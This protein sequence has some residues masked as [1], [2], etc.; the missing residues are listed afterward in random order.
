VAACAFARDGKSRWWEEPMLDVGRREF[1]MLA[2]G[3]A[4]AWPLVARSQQLDRIARIG[5]LGLPSASQHAPRSDA[6]RAGL[7]NLGYIEGRNLHIEFRFAEGDSDRLPGLAAEL[8]GL[9]VDVIVTHATGVPVA[10]RAT[11]T[12][13]I[14]MAT[15]GDA[16]AAGIVAGLAHPGGNVTGS[17]FFNPEVLAKRLELVKEAVP[18]MTRAAVLLIQDSPLNASIREAIQRT[19]TGL[20]VG[21]QP[22]EISRLTELQSAFAVWADRQIGALVVSDHPLFVTNVNVIAAL[23]AK[24]HLPSIGPLELAA[25]GGLMA[26]GVNF[27]EQ[28]RRAAVFV[29]KILKGAK[30]QD[31]PVEQATKFET[32]INLKT[33]KALGLDVPT[34]ILLR[35][36]EVIE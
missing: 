12:I 23:A 20:R 15:Y 18:S 16:V 14:V 27:S 21:F 10:Q 32:I 33:A 13:P 22:F 4:A 35:A 29:D 2:G 7:R 17:T 3:A 11:A 31:I 24:H 36:D 1:L 5:Y 30:P 25:S 28:F 34:S 6:L 26:Y 19:A 8:V 9:N